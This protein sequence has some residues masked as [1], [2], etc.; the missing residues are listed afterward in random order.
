MHYLLSHLVSDMHAAN[1]SWFTIGHLEYVGAAFVARFESCSKLW[2]ITE[3]N[4]DTQRFLLNMKTFNELQNF[5]HI[6]TTVLKSKTYL[7]QSFFHG[8][9]G[10]IIDQPQFHDHCVVTRETFAPEDK[11]KCVLSH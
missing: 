2:I 5:L 8:E 11:S 6:R 10:D 7:L 3:G 1:G 4:C 9:P